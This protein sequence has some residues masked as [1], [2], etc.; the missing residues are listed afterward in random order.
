MQILRLS[1]SSLCHFGM[2]KTICNGLSRKMSQER[3]GKS[4]SALH[5]NFLKCADAVYFLDGV[6]QTALPCL[7]GAE[8]WPENLFILKF[9][10]LV[11]KLQQ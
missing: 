3:T 5:A 11:T 6:Q 1:P 10:L 4:T 2:Q 9:P 8:K 7:P